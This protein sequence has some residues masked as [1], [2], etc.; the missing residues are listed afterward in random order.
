MLGSLISFLFIRTTAAAALWQSLNNNFW[1][2]HWTG[3]F[4]EVLPY[5]NH[6]FSQATSEFSAQLSPALAADLMPVYSQLCQPDPR[7]RGYPGQPLNKVALER[8]ITKFD[9]M[10]RKAHIGKYGTP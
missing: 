4:D 5:L 1:P 7:K 6:A 2:A 3:T 8:F 9:V 10:A